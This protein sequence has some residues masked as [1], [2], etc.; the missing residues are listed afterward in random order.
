[1]RRILVI[2]LLLGITGAIA[3]WLRG[4]NG[5]AAK[6]ADPWRSVPPMAAAI[7][8]VPD[9][10]NTWE[11]FKSTSQLWNAWSAYPACHAADSIMG[12]LR[13]KL[14]GGDL[15][16]ALTASDD[17]FNLTLAWAFTDPR[18]LAAFDAVLPG[19]GKG[20]KGIAATAGLPAM[21]C[22]VKDG[23]FLL[24]TSTAE[25]DDAL[26]RMGNSAPA[27]DSLLTAAR[28]SLG[29]DGDAHILLHT[30]RS[31]RLLDTWLTP[32]VLAPLEGLDGW[33]ALDLRARPEATLLSGMLFARSVP[34]TLVATADQGSGAANMGRVLPPKLTAHWQAYVT[35]A[36][37]YHA[38][39]VGEP[40]DL[41]PAYGSWVYGPV[42]IAS[43]DGDRAW[44][45]MRTDDPTRAVEA[46]GARCNGG[47]DTLAYRSVRMT[48]SP[49]TLALAAVWG[50][51]FQRFG[52]PWWCLLGDRMVFSESVN[53]LREAIDAWTDGGSFQQDTRS[54][55]L[56]HRYASDAAYSWWCDLSAG[57]DALR[58]LMRPAGTA[59]ADAHKG[60]WA[61]T[62]AALLQLVPDA[63]GRYQ[64]T[65]CIGGTSR[66]LPANSG[67]G[68]A[69]ASEGRWSVS[70]GSPIIAGPF[71]LTDHLSRTKQIL[72]QD[73]KNRIHLI[74][75]TGKTLWQR[76]LDGPL[77]GGAH[78][79]DRYKNGKLQMLLN[80]ADRVYLIDRNGENVTG[81]PIAL[82]E[83][84]SGPLNVFDYDSK[85]E[86]RV[87]VPTTGARLLNFDLSGKPTEGW[88]PPRTPAACA[89]PVE[90]L[91]I[92]G[93]DHLLLVDKDGG[94][95]VLDRRA[96]PRYTPKLRVK[97]AARVIGLAPGLEIGETRIV[98]EDVERNRLRGR[99]DGPVDTLTLG[100]DS[101]VLHL[102]LP[103][104]WAGTTAEPLPHG[105]VHDIDLDG[106]R[107]R[108]T[109][110][111][112]GHVVVETVP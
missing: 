82:P 36:A 58:P 65:A 46:L 2:V 37:R 23:L 107:E 51:P 69:T 98:W 40:S 50:P 28:A 24:S 77:I 89:L 27:G 61:S 39:A 20:R 94:I 75:C 18:D 71:L 81:F 53:A 73:K 105:L 72:V 19:V 11:R 93:K 47:C 17:G 111:A 76:E 70:V 15:V 6:P 101:I 43:A 112:D 97:D 32:D 91:R 63:P 38:G 100:A 96:A 104:P 16:A 1:M 109:A 33:A 14:D 10:L 26:A 52:R 99:L 110:T 102:P 108:V 57:I 21:E 25:L 74:T 48:R 49:D 60:G 12:A 68:I 67:S 8:H 83:E 35:D 85:K 44:A 41:F 88:A 95:T 4:W 84:A 80:T 103:Y 62:G 59:S 9:P 7:I 106:V 87:L 29:A 34:R 56:F 79:V 64:I 86:Y 13:G 3:W 54:G 31:G 55:A 22:T 42:G 66:A 78:Q 92:R 45:V 30:G 5:G 90:H